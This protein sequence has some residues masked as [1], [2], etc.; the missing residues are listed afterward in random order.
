MG[1]GGVI[2]LTIDQNEPG[3]QADYISIQNGNDATCIAWVSVS[4]F[5]GSTKGAWTGDIGYGC[6]QN[7]YMSNQNAG[8]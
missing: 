2:E 6:G 8:E 3:V 4:Q 1:D 5:D 7:W